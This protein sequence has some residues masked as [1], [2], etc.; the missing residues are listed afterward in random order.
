MR[1]LNK[2]D[3]NLYLEQ[4]AMS[5]FFL[6]KDCLVEKIMLDYNAH[7]K[8]GKPA[9]L[10]SSLINYL[11]HKVK[12]ADGESEFAKMKLTRTASEIWESGKSSGCTDRALL[13]ATCARTI[14]LPATL[15]HT[16]SEKWI[17]KLESGEDISVCIGHSFCEVFFGNKWILVDPTS[18]VILNDYSPER[19]ELPITLG[20]ENVFIPYKRVVDFE[21]PQTVHEHNTIMKNLCSEIIRSREA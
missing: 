11:L 9:N 20:G 5:K 10:I 1:K 3:C 2:N 17:K 14:G 7:L 21:K 8:N 16:A 15:L 19:I 6:D 12:P 18:R 13:F 4:G